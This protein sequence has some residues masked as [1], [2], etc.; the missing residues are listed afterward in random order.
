METLA[1]DFRGSLENKTPSICSSNN[2]I[3]ISLNID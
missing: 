2:L 1:D 3:D